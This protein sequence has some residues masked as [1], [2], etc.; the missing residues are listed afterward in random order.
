MAAQL[1]VLVEEGLDGTY[2][3]PV[4]VEGVGNHVHVL[5]SRGDDLAAEV[6]GQRVDLRISVN[7]E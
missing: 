3:L 5:G 1:Q 6:V 4:P 2:I 7:R